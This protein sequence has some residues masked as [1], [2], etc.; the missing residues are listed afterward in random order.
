[1]AQQTIIHFI[2]GKLEVYICGY[3]TVKR[4]ELLRRFVRKGMQQNICGFGMH[5]DSV[6]G[7]T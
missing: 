4:M 1:M 6:Q 7:S 5:G 2:V 3:N